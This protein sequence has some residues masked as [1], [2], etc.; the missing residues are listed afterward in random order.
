[1]ATYVIGDIHGC[2]N[3][4]L[5]LLDVIKFDEKKDSLIFLGDILNRGPD[6]LKTIRFIKSLGD[7]STVILGNH[8][9][10]FLAISYGYIPNP[11]KNNISDLLKSE[12][13]PDIRQ[14]LCNQKLV[15]K[16]KKHTMVHAGIPPMWSTNKASEMA[17]EL[18]NVL[19]VPATRKLFLSNL[20]GNEPNMWSEELEGVNRWRCIANYFTRMRLCNEEGRLNFKYQHGLNEK[21]PE[22]WD[23]W[24]NFKNK[25]IKKKERIIFGHWAALCGKTGK[26]KYIAMDTGCVWGYE[27]TAYCLSTNKIFSVPSLQTG[28][29]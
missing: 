15:I 9:L 8:D 6:S 1:M 19:R 20:F 29:F 28:T 22:G 27:L 11:K 4:L 25:H 14:W 13:L 5:N 12:D 10:A 24:F 23:A 21:L 2:Y 26:N 17:E 3:E 7:R 18:E 16:K